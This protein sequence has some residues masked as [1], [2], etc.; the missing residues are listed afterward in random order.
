MINFPYRR[1]TNNRVRNRKS[2]LEQLDVDRST[3]EY[4][5]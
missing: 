2:P 4:Y 3:D 5:S 1:I